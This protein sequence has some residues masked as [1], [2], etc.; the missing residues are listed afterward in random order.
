[1]IMIETMLVTTM[2]I[3]ILSSAWCTPSVCFVA[4][5]LP[6]FVWRTDQTNYLGWFV[7]LAAQKAL[8]LE[9]VQDFSLVD[10]LV[11]AAPVCNVSY[12]AVV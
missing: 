1:M 10:A 11:S 2:A 5:V 8:R 9:L 3:F 6:C 12:D 4:C 7:G